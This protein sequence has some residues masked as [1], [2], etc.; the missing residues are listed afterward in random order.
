MATVVNRTTKQICHS[1]NTPDYPTADWIINPDLT[2]LTG[3]ASKYWNISGDAITE[4][5]QAE[6]DQ[7]DL[8]ARAASDAAA[9][10]PSYADSAAASLAGLSVGTQ[11][12][13]GDTL[14][15]VHL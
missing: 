1:A 2:A 13:T 12:R 5:T 9:D 4:M 6:K 11:Y 3:I 14:K 10:L 7:V 8:D 15:I